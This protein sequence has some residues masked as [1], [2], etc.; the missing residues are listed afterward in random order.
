MSK[1]ESNSSSPS[2][3]SSSPSP[4]SPAS[5]N[6]SKVEVNFQIPHELTDKDIL[7]KASKPKVK[8]I[9]DDSKFR[10]FCINGDP[11]VVDNKKSTSILFDRSFTRTRTI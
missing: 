6:S 8:A 3:T 11:F 1:Q 10:S 7:I 5:S 4:T 9:Q 2:P